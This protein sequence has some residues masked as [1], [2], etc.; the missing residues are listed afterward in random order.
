MVEQLVERRPKTGFQRFKRWA[1]LGLA[2]VTLATAGASFSGIAGNAFQSQPEGNQSTSKAVLAAKKPNV[3]PSPEPTPTPEPEVKNRPNVIIV[4]MDDL[5]NYNLGFWNRFPTIRREFIDNGI[6]FKNA[7][8]ETSLCCPGRAGLYTGQHTFNHGVDRNKA[9]LFKPSMTIAT[10]LDEVG[11][12]T[13]LAGKYFNGSQHLGDKTPLG[14]DKFYMT[15]GK[16]GEYNFTEWVN[17]K[18]FWH[19]TGSDDFQSDLVFR[20]GIDAI[21]DTDPNKP[22]FAVISTRAA[23]TSKATKAPEPA[24]RNIGAPNCR[25]ARWDNPAYNE[26]YVSD[27]PRYVRNA[28]PLVGPFSPYSLDFRKWCE[29]VLGV[30]QNLAKLLKAL[31][32]TGRYQNTLLILTSDN[33]MN[34]GEHGLRHKETPYAVEIPLFISWPKVVKDGRTEREPV[35]NIDVPVTICDIVTDCHLGPYP[36]GQKKP[37]GLSFLPIITNEKD[38]LDRDAVLINH[39]YGNPKDGI[40]GWK[41]IINTKDGWMY[42]EYKTGETEVYNRSKDPWLLNNLS[43]KKK[44]ASEKRKLRIEMKRL[45]RLSKS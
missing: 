44:F 43:R 12:Y 32:Q 36:N 45:M 3:D 6:T 4:L 22:I 1:G 14:W 15:E 21:K 2:G 17:G 16:Y 37:D 38:T 8:G 31:K 13:V 33:G 27:K 40:P 28:D 26:R 34:D 20:R 35:M 10:A 9:I 42:V 25:D 24:R 5:S 30:D 23:H 41:G 7:R 11:Y 39:W 19:G 18:P 29:S